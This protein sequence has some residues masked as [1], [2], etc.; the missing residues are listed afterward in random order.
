MGGKGTGREG[1][2]LAAGCG[3]ATGGEGRDDQPRG[4]AALAEAL[5]MRD[6]KWRTWGRERC[7]QQVGNTGSWAALVSYGMRGREGSV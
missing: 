6:G 7:A 3:W 5:G 4:G 1:A 2:N